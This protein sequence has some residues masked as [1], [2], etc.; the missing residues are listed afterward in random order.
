MADVDDDD[1]KLGRERGRNWTVEEYFA[2][3]RAADTVYEKNAVSGKPS[4][5]IS[6]ISRWV[7]QFNGDC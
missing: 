6:D 5:S 1:K 7:Y 4:A 3:L 2:L